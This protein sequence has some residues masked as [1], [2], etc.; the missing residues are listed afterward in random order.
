MT[1]HQKTA[2][3]IVDSNEYSTILWNRGL[4]WNIYIFQMIKIY[5]LTKPGS[6]LKSCMRILES[7]T[8]SQHKTNGLNKFH[9]SEQHTEE[10]NIFY[11]PALVLPNLRQGHKC[12]RRSGRQG[13]QT[14]S[15]CFKFNWLGKVLTPFTEREMFGGGDRFSLLV[16]LSP[17]AFQ[18][19]E[20]WDNNHLGSWR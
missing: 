11:R 14:Q 7:K 19:N 1:I 13:S 12:L 16:Y 3:G 10:I 9:L 15:W 5:I 2:T 18:K 20:R 4:W 17:T 6:I 8:T